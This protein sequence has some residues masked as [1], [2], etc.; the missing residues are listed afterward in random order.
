MQALHSQNQRAQNI[1]ITQK[2]QRSQNVETQKI[3]KT[4]KLNI[5]SKTENLVWKEGF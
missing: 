1:K 4:L 5:L 2:N 3:N